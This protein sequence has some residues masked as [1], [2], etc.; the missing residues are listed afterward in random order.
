MK[1]MKSELIIHPRPYQGQNSFSD[2]HFSVFVFVNGIK[3]FL[4]TDI[5]ISVNVNHT[6]GGATFSSFLCTFRPLFPTKTCLHFYSLGG[7]YSLVSLLGAPQVFLASFARGRHFV[8]VNFRCFRPFKNVPTQNPMFCTRSRYSDICS[9]FPSEISS[10][11]CKAMFI[12]LL[13]GSFGQIG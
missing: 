13:L 7:D 5:S 3:I 6:A 8:F 4:L 2:H 12:M 10:P 11:T 1:Y 9:S